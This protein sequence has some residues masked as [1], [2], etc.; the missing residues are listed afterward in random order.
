M[1][2]KDAV[3]GFLVGGEKSDCQSIRELAK[4][5]EVALPEV[6]A[7][8]SRDFVQGEQQL[9]L[10]KAMAWATSF[11]AMILGSV[12]VLNTMMMTVFERTKE[13]G[14]LRASAGSE[15]AS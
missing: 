7:T 11:I 2:R 14:I 8:P 4:R 6:A 9:K 1:G 5:I 12:G 15:P 10:V 13:I 3:S